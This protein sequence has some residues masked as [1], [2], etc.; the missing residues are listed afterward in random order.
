MTLRLECIRALLVQAMLGSVAG[1]CSDSD[2]QVSRGACRLVDTPGT[3]V[4]TRIP[5]DPASSM[6]IIGI[7]GSFQVHS[8]FNPNKEGNDEITA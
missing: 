6:T 7:V 5:Q 3:R 1:E 4:T 2:L 8:A